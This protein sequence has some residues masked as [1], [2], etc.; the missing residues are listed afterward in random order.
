[1]KIFK[2]ER[3]HIDTSSDYANTNPL[4]LALMDNGAEVESV[5]VAI[6]Y[7]EVDF[8]D[9]LIEF[10]I[11][12]DLAKWQ[13]EIDKLLVKKYGEKVDIEERFGDERAELTAHID[14]IF[15]MLD[16]DTEQPELKIVTDE[17]KQ[18]SGL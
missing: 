13:T 4:A 7:G 15:V 6:D 9:G 16:P 1:M 14:E 12:P 18:A 3:K 5:E 8:G 10:D 2:V 11:H 17:V